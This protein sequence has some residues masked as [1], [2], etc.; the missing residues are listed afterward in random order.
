MPISVDVLMACYNSE[1]Y[2][3]RAINSVLNQQTAFDLRL[4]V[5]DDCSL[6]GSA[7]LLRTL[8]KKH[9]NLLVEISSN[10]C[11]GTKTFCKMLSKVNADYVMFLDADDMWYSSHV[12]ENL[13]TY[14]ERTGDLAVTSYSVIGND[15]QSFSCVQR[16]ISLSQFAAGCRFPMGGTAIRLNDKIVKLWNDAIPGVTLHQSDLTV[17]L[18][19]IADEPI[20]QLPIVSLKYNARDVETEFNYNSITTGTNKILDRLR[21]VWRNLE[22]YWY[23]PA[24]YILFTRVLVRFLLI[25]MYE[26]KLGMRFIKAIKNAR[27]K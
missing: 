12:V 10:N 22:F 7:K 11:G 21:I 3:E 13:I 20:M 14:L 2:L 16:T 1:R 17:C 4:I 24:Y 15:V 27:S 9:E 23:R 8:A 6:D 26:T 19:V 5:V 18:S 25:P